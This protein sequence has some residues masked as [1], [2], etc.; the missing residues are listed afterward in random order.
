M[1][2]TIRHAALEDA[3][4]IADLLNLAYRP[5]PGR[6][7]WT[8]ESHLV[9]GQ[10]ASAE[11]VKSALQQTGS[12]MALKVTADGHL[13]ACLHLQGDKES[14]SIGMFAVDTAAQGQGLGREMLA[15]AEREAQARWSCRKTCM[16]VVAQRPELIAYY[17]RRGYLP[18]GETAAFPW[19]AS[20]GSPLGT[21]LSLCLL[22]KTLT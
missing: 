3:Q 4:A 11:Q 15:W 19:E 7:G 10:R 17:A 20:V 18:T 5:P 22:E 12:I 16:S 1:T 9:A 8:H 13:L 21:A 6:E 2:A 14:A